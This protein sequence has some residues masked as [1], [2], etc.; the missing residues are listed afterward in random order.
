MADIT[1]LKILL[2]IDELDTTEDE[3]LE[4]LKEHSQWKIKAYLQLDELTPF[5]LTLEWVADE[6]T[7]KR[8]NKLSGEGLL[9]EGVGGVTH[10]FEDD[11][12]KEFIPVLDNYI[13][14]FKPSTKKGRLVML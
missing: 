13:A 11:F 2:N 10:T 3:L 1:R 7:A 5:P 9:A 14:H 4:V 8:Y 12:L 6:L